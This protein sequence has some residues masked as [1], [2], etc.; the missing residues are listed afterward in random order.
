VIELICATC[1]KTRSQNPGD[2]APPTRC[3]SCSGVL[4]VKTEPAPPPAAPPKP[5][6][7]LV[8]TAFGKYHLIDEIGRGSMGVV[9]D[10]QDTQ[11]HRRVAVKVIHTP[12]GEQRDALN[13]WQRFMQE[14]R[15]TAN[16][17]KHPNI[18]TV[19]EAG[20]QDSRRYIAMEYVAGQ[21][22]AKWRTGRSL[23]E[24]VRLIRDVAIAVHHA[25]EHGI[26]H[27]D[28]K[29]GNVLVAKGDIPV[30]TDFGL[31]TFERK[32]VSL[33]ITPKGFAVGSPAYMSPEQARGQKD[34]DR[35]TDVYALGIM[36]YEAVAGHP[37]FD[38]KNAV[39]TLS[40]VVE[41]TSVPPS[42]GAP[43]PGADPVL[44]RICMKAIA[45][46]ARDRFT[47]C[48]ELAQALT[49]WLEQVPAAKP[50][51]RLSVPLVAGIAV[52]CAILLGLLFWQ[53]T[54]SDRR[55][56]EL[57]AL[58]AGTQKEIEKLK[59]P[60]PPAASFSVALRPTDFAL[61]G[62]DGGN[63]TATRLNFERNVLFDATATLPET[64]EY[65]ITVTAG[66]DAARNEFARFKLYVDGKAVAEVSMTS[67]KPQDYK[68]VTRCASGERRIGIRFLNDFWVAEPREDRNLFVH[69][70]VLRRLK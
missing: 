41:G 30:V 36:L 9:Y 63:A 34:V 29:P 11:L 19:F 46:E 6:G 28:L 32:G 7:S 64:G 13:D 43:V 5:G 33:S 55:E 65:E 62:T 15:L 48:S 20:V 69:G 31:A 59:A 8:G 2:P 16:V 17:A 27:R 47:T 37:P 3:P 57:K 49:A 24:Q 25:H 39:E 68:V 70:V 42:Q 18:V 1:G 51:A 4:V 23:R 10:A 52:L 35:T 21:S 26:I 53:K 38:G 22:M 66:C 45:R 14:A 56:A 12:G 40:R 61:D 44:D 54:A 67:E 50:Q 58:L 60:P